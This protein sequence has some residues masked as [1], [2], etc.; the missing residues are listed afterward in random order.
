METLQ[1]VREWINPGFYCVS[2]DIK[3]AYLHIR[4]HKG[5]RKYLRFNWL[6]Q[7]LQWCVIPFGLTC[8]PRVLTKIL[9]PVIAFIR[10]T[11][12]ILLS[13]FMDDILLQ[14]SSVEQCI[15]H[16]HI[17]IIVLMSLGWSIKWAKCDLVPKQN[18]R[19]LGFDF[20]TNEMTISCPPVKITNL[21][22]ICLKIFLAKNVSVHLLEQLIGTIESVRPAVPYAALYYRSLQLQ[23][24]VA[25]QGI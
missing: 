14:A 13:I 16:C 2:L 7:L 23:L 24:L 4:V 20:N 19:H 18:I 11:W 12:G 10:S 25:K 21:Q 8:S 15:L 5:S 17:V 22:D 6:G 9:K 1:S 3:D